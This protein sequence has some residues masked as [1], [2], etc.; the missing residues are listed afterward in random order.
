MKI[1]RRGILEDRSLTDN[2]RGWHCETVLMS[3]FVQGFGAERGRGGD[4]WAKGWLGMGAGKK[5][6]RL[7][8]GLDG[9]ASTAFP[10]VVVAY[11]AAV[12]SKEGV[13]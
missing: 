1:Q 8:D 13:W 4:G 9:T 3:H 2:D 11:C 5:V 6:R 7:T 12:A 10:R